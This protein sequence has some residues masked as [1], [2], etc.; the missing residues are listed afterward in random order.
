M[1]G[2]CELHTELVLELLGVLQRENTSQ[3]TNKQKDKTQKEYWKYS[4]F[5]KHKMNE[6]LLVCRLDWMM[7]AKRPQFYSR[8]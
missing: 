8:L 3:K 4:L 7:E 1:H 2:Q 6:A 5:E